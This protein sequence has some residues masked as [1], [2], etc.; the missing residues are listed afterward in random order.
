MKVR[1]R[2]TYDKP[3]RLTSE[4]GTT[5]EIPSGAVIVKE[6]DHFIY[7]GH[8]VMMRDSLKNCLERFFTEEEEVYYSR[9][10]D[11]AAVNAMAALISVYGGLNPNLVAE[12]AVKH[13]KALVNLIVEEE[14]NRF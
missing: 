8:V 13:A 9:L 4:Y 7:N 1:Y 11:T 14:K 12:R 2:Y 10:G 3:Y 6:G 5:I